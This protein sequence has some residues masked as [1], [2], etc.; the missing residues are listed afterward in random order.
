MVTLEME[1]ETGLEMGPGHLSADHQAGLE[2]GKAAYPMGLKS[3]Q[4]THWETGTVGS[5]A[6]HGHCR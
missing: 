6:W 1:Q 4:K 3:I 2:T 5:R